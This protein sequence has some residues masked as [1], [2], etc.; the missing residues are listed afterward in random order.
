MKAPLPENM[1]NLRS[2][3]GVSFNKEECYCC[4][5]GY[6]EDIFYTRSLV[7]DKFIFTVAASMDRFDNVYWGIKEI[8]DDTHQK[9]SHEVR[10]FVLDKLRK[11]LHGNVTNCKRLILDILSLS[12]EK[13]IPLSFS[14]HGR[15]VG[16]TFLKN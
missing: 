13:N 10:A 14:H 15:F 8:R 7:T 9:Q 6:G 4:A 3:E 11:I 16:Y 1:P 2:Y 12:G 5:A